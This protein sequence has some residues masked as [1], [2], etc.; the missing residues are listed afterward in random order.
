MLL[1]LFAIAV[2]F[3]IG[4]IRG[5]AWSG[6]TSARLHRPGF[7]VFAIFTMLV[8]NLL[9]P[10]FPIVWVVAGMVSFI[11][12]AIKNLQLTG[13]II[14]IIGVLMNLAP[15]L[16]NGAVPVSELALVSV[17]DVDDAGRANIDGLRESTETATS[18]GAFGDVIPVPIV[19]SVVSIGDLVMLVALVDIIT[20]LLLRSRTREELDD[21][22]VTFAPTPEET[23][24][25]PEVLSPLSH[26]VKG[27]PAHAAHRR[28][29]R[30]AAPSTHVPAHAK[31]SPID[32]DDP[33]T[34]IVLDGPSAYIEQAAPSEPEPVALLAGTESI[35]DSSETL[36]LDDDGFEDLERSLDELEQL[37]AQPAS[38]DDAEAADELEASTEAADELEASTEADATD[39]ELETS[40]GSVDNKIAPFPKTEIIV[41]DDPAQTR[42]EGEDTVRLD[43]IESADSDE[44]DETV[45]ADETDEAVA[46]TEETEA[47]AAPAHG[48]PAPAAV[49]ANA[50]A[51]AAQAR[52][53]ES[54]TGSVDRNTSSTS[55]DSNSVDRR[56][57]IDLTTSPTDEQ[58]QEFLRRRAEADELV[59][60]RA[61]GPGPQRRGRAPRRAAE[62]ADLHS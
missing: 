60:A 50:A 29:R 49:R 26:S 18:F 20:N 55:S 52:K 31:E 39:D 51:A 3:L 13:M 8:I 6:V 21:A 2:G 25:R 44:V 42:S 41:P 30:K 11:W 9:G 38:N 33:D 62:V 12:F 36:W 32:L 48:A 43:R 56:P 34:V 10:A 54:S 46:A 37:A 5:G 23:S 15:I 1:S 17:G 16:F 35:D 61:A 7:L 45:E 59:A 22:G 24:E 40:T 53:S 27:R 58:L 47:P 14:M 19:N 4:R 28:P 57:I